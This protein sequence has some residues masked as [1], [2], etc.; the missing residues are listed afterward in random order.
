M[1]ELFEQYTVTEIIVFLFLLGVAFKEALSLIDWF[2][3]RIKKS[4]KKDEYHQEMDS[5]FA[6]CKEIVASIQQQQLDFQE[7]LNLMRDSIDRL[8]ESDKNDIKAWIVEKHHYFCYQKGYIDDYSLDS[9]EKRYAD[10]VA[11]NGNSFVHDLME[12]VRALPKVSSISYTQ[13]TIT[14]K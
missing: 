12:D 2:K 9:M 8:T 14:K 11:E 7:Q 1:K 10:Y 13:H 4:I 5:Q 6:A 3:T